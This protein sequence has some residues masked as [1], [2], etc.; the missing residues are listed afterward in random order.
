MQKHSRQSQEWDYY[1]ALALLVI[2][3]YVF[4][5]KDKL[6]ALFNPRKKSLE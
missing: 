4:S 3:L 5:L 6:V 1:L 2:V